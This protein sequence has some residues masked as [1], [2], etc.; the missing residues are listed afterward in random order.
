MIMMM[1]MIMMMMIMIMR[2]CP[3][4]LGET[5]KEAFSVGPLASIALRY[6][7]VGLSPSFV[8]FR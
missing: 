2:A 7:T 4:L 8:F 5:V 3:N 6:W 1:T